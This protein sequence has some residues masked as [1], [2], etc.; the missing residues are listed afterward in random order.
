MVLSL[1]CRGTRS[2]VLE[3]CWGVLDIMAYMQNPS[4]LI[5]VLIF[6]RITLVSSQ[7]LQSTGKQSAKES[8]RLLL[9]S[10]RTRRLRGGWNVSKEQPTTRQV[11]SPGP[12]R[13][14]GTQLEL[15]AAVLRNIC[16]LLNIGETRRRLLFEREMVTERDTDRFE[17]VLS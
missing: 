15:G 16:H 6:A 10:L 8:Q 4:R 7:P 3:R 11:L 13:I 12:T 1:D 9:L 5:T 2:T 17:T 14:L